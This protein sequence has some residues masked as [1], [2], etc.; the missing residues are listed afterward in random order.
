MTLWKAEKKYTTAIAA[1]LSIGAMFSAGAAFAGGPYY[2]KFN[3]HTY[4]IY[5]DVNSCDAEQGNCHQANFCGTT[6]Y[7]RE[8]VMNLIA[9]QLNR[10]QDVRVM[11]TSSSQVVCTLS[12]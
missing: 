5:A 6:L 11:Q 3:A 1:A 2:T 12:M 7:A 9:D 8:D 4:Y 10:N